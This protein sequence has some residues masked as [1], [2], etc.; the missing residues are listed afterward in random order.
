M[1]LTFGGHFSA[2]SSDWQ[3]VLTLLRTFQ[4]KQFTLGFYSLQKTKIHYLPLMELSDIAIRSY[5]EASKGLIMLFTF[6]FGPTYFIPTRRNSSKKYTWPNIILS[7][8]SGLGKR[9]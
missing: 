9:L 5:L 1:P 2:D 8:L 7:D 3:T 6:P 4:K